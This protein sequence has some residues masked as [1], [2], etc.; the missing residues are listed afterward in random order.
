MK[1]SGYCAFIVTVTV[2][3][4]QGY[5]PRKKDYKFLGVGKSRD[6]GKRCAEKAVENI[7]A[8]L[9]EMCEKIPLKFQ[10]QVMTQEVVYFEIEDKVFVK[11][12]KPAPDA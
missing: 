9:G 6:Y 12:E 2:K 7:Q 5:S 8:Q 1:K 3:A 10:W 11:P 4:P